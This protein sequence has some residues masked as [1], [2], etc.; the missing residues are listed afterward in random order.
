MW[1]RAPGATTQ[2][3]CSKLKPLRP[4]G[5][6][7]PFDT[8]GGGCGAAMR[9]MCI[10]LL[11]NKPEHLDDLIEVSVES[12][13]MTHNH[14]T[15]NEQIKYKTFSSLCQASSSSVNYFGKLESKLHN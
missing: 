5:H 10:G 3:S 11:F 12:G 6:I 9:A 1:G 14:P 15:G 7:I 8:H 13:R 4:D 2:S